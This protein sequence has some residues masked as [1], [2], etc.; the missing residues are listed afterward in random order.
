MIQQISTPDVS[1]HLICSD[2]SLYNWLIRQEIPNMAQWQRERGS[3][4]AGIKI[5][6]TEEGTLLIKGSKVGQRAFL[7]QGGWG[8]VWAGGRE[9]VGWAGIKARYLVNFESLISVCLSFYLSVCLESTQGIFFKF[10]QTT[11]WVLSS[12]KGDPTEE[13]GPK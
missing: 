2:L 8:A 11:W 13:L 3:R 7:S 6:E 12:G 9:A 4:S 1:L 10:N 5:R